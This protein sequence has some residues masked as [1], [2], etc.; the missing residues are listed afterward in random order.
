MQRPR[1]QQRFPTD[2]LLPAKRVAG[3]KPTS[4]D[5]FLSR[6]P[7]CFGE[8]VR[9]PTERLVDTN[10][11]CGP[12]SFVERL[13][14][15][16]GL[17]DRIS[18]DEL[19]HYIDYIDEFSRTVFTGGLNW[20]RN[21]DRSW[22][23]LADPVSATVTVPGL[24]MAGTAGPVLGFMGCDRASEVVTGP[25]RE[26]MIDGAGRWLQQ[27]RPDEVNAAWLDFL[28]GLELR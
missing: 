7:L 14:E 12:A 17:P 26:V 1:N 21:L 13:P 5:P 18:R 22:E 24:F 25:Y 4:R 23:I 11:G 27:E 20:Y 3:R 16:N 19:D 15:P 28:E 9:A 8:T 10:G 2:H 6:L